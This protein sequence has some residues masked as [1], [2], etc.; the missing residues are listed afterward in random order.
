[1]H[2]Y[3]AILPKLFY[4]DSGIAEQDLLASSLASTKP[5]SLV[6]VCTR[7]VHYKRF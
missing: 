3:Q 1:M 7:A 2:R 5:K 4:W 6:R